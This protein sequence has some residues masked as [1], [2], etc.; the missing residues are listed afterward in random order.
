MQLTLY[1]DYAIRTLVYL[2]THPARVVP[3]SEIGGVFG[4]STNHLAKV[5]K[6]LTRAGLVNARR[7][8]DGGLT[9]AVAPEEIRLG[10]L[11]RLCESH[12]L[13]ECFD[14]KTSTCQLTGAC[15]VERAVREA[16]EAFFAVLDR[17]TLAELVGN[18][19]QLIQ[20]LTR[21]KRKVP[22]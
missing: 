1:T 11:V 21:S 9:L 14:R 10:A 17:Y 13:L 18:R 2:G 16:Q 15:R 22:A 12:D 5:A 8:R 20:L 4:V 19:P 3:V 7:G 6:M